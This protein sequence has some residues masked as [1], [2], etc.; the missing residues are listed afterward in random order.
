MSESTPTDGRGAIHRQPVVDLSHLKSAEELSAI[1]SI[2]RV[3]TVVVPQALAAAYATIP[4]TRIGA[5]IYVA[6]GVN[7]RVHTGKLTLGGDGLGDANDVLVVVGMLII[8]S[9]VTGTVPHRISVV[10]LALAPR[11]SEGALG[12]IMAGG[13]GSVSYYRYVEG[14]DV[15]TLTGQ[16]NLSGASLA[17]TAGQPDDILIA[18]GQ[19]VITGEVTEVGYAQ[20]IVAGQ[21]VAPV[22]TRGILEPRVQVH[23]QVA[24]YRTDEPRVIAGD[25][26]YGADFFRLLDHPV[27][28]IVL[29]DLTIE[30]GVTETAI[31]EKVTDIVLLGDLIAPADV[32]AV[33]QV[34]AVESYGDIR[35]AD[36]PAS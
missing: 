23:G 10:G 31:R 33:L 8:T 12:P 3:G 4:A 28:L 17:N 35:I 24:W 22:A 15:N 14:Q 27:S 18:A 5:T 13:T 1:T 26:S 36:G 20:I 21:L 32:V 7:V 2:E 16:V 25:A 19:V 6:D 11:G 9:P 34:L 30:P 29:G